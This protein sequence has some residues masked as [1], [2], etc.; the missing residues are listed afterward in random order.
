[1][2]G[3]VRIKN[4]TTSVM[5]SINASLE[6]MLHGNVNPYEPISAKSIKYDEFMASLSPLDIESYMRCD[7]GWVKKPG[8]ECSWCKKVDI[9]KCIHCKKEISNFNG[10]FT[11]SLCRDEIIKKKESTSHIIK[12][13]EVDMIG[14][15]R[16]YV[17]KQTKDIKEF[18]VKRT[19]LSGRTHT[20]NK[21]ATKG[22]VRPEIIKVHVDDSGSY[23]TRKRSGELRRNYVPV[24]EGNITCRLCGDT[25]HV[26]QFHKS[27][28]NKKGRRIYCSACTSI[29]KRD[30]LI[31]RTNKTGKYAPKEDLGL[32]KKRCKTCNEVKET[33][34]FYFDS[35][36]KD[37][38]RSECK[39]CEQVKSTR[40]RREK[41]GVES[42]EHNELEL[43]GSKVCSS[44]N[45]MRQ[46]NR[47][48]KDKM[49][50]CCR[51]DICKYCIRKAHAHSFYWSRG[52]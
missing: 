1:M 7:C 52:Q 31:N 20:C 30:N 17:C 33:G 3:Q 40:K 29:Q 24:M 49:N 15:R 21:C 42:V 2:G 14:E 43:W 27:S 22:R 9:I 47:F 12:K 16:C 46:V 10:R 23:V 38:L 19:R 39:R 36:K 28:Q 51:N 48:G 11:C 18:G 44:C 4:I 5:S 35:T 8:A 25:K 50:G 26:S 41:N 34:E 45:T 13:Y 6:D 37:G 32:N